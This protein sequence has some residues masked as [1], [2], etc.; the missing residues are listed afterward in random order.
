MMLSGKVKIAEWIKRL[1]LILFAL[2]I[3]YLLVASIFSTCYLGSY[4]YMT[5]AQVE[6]VNVEHTFYIRDNFVQHFI[7]FFGFSFLLLVLRVRNDGKDSGN[8]IS[9]NRFSGNKYLGIAACIAAGIVS[10]LIVLAGQYAPKFDQK[11]VVDAAAALNAHDYSDFEVGGYLYI[12]PF[13]MGI[14]LYFRVLSWLFGSLNYI[15][16]EIVN[17]V[18]IA[19]AYYFFMKIADILWN[20]EYWCRSGTAI[21]CLFFTPFLMYTTFLYGTVVG[22]A[23]ALLS[24]YMMLLYMSEPKIWY[25]LLSAV[26]MGLATV[27]K[28]NYAIY[29]IAQVIIIV[30]RILADKSIEHKR[31]YGRLLLIGMILLC[32][33]IGRAGVNASI[34]NANHGE[35]AKGIPMMAWVVMGLQDGKGAPGW[36]NAYNNAV[37]ERNDYDYDRTQA[38]VMDDLKE[39]I[40]GMASRPMESISFFV[41]K[42]SSQ[43]NNPTFQSLWVLEGRS[44]REDSIWILQGKGRAAYIFWVNLLQ[45]WILAGVFLYTVLRLRKSSVEEIILPIT[46]IGGFVFHL[47]WEAEGLYAIL[48]FPLLLPLSVCGYKEWALWLY[49][50]RN[51][52]AVEGWKSLTGKKLKK[53][54][55]M[56]AAIAVVFCVLSY[57]EPFAKMFA[58]NEDTGFF[59][60]YTQETVNESDLSVQWERTNE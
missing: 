5:A 18:W 46:F 36:Y 30:L 51:E 57:T 53:K 15:A 25:M 59:D 27:F 45:T 10:L 44:E 11:H 35:E 60:T 56:G 58:R 20:K 12:F 9:E 14:V 43:W 28:S 31:V 13:Q 7:V 52:I 1:V 29:M 22:M 16:F 24:F 55:W 26:S 48:Y 33:I 34:K 50:R 37:Y 38:A 21:L 6:E 49:A 19:A 17:A 23:F 41:K 4:R 54:I 32:F 40:K 39:R 3:G 8:K 47:F 2:I 42:V